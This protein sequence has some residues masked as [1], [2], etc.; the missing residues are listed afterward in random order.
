M[1]IEL[2][3]ENL[4][5]GNENEKK[6]ILQFESVNNSVLTYQ[7]ILSL[8]YIFFPPLYCN[9]RYTQLIRMLY[10]NENKFKK[11]KETKS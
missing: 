3:D 7:F 2:L 8:I 10:L 11:Q 1:C 4:C 5:A 6:E 9:Y